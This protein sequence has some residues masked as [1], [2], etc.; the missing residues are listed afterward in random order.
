[1]FDLSEDDRW[2]ETY[3]MALWGELLDCKHDIERSNDVVLLGEDGPVAVDH[4]VG[5]G[6]LLPKVDNRVGLKLLQKK[7]DCASLLD[8]SFEV[9]LFN[10]EIYGEGSIRSSLSITLG[11]VD[12]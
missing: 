10:L 11:A 12:N 5:G 9:L 6:P 2:H 7:N 8:P 4:R 3:Q 1:V